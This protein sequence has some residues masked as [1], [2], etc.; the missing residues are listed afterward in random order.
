MTKVIFYN[1]HVCD[2]LWNECV[3]AWIKQQC[4]MEKKK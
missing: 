2:Y 4:D 3:E 1:N